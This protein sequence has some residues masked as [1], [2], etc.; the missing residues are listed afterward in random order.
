MVG[1]NIDKE[2]RDRIDKF[3]RKLSKERGD[4]F[5]S[6]NVAILILLEEHG[7]IKKTFNRVNKAQNLV[8]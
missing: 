6:A 8:S 1:I 5:I 7:E 2:T 4:C 3:R